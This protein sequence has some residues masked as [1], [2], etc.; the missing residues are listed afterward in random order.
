MITGDE[1]WI[2]YNNQTA[3]KEVE[4]GEAPERQAKIEI[5][6]KNCRKAALSDVIAQKRP[7]LINRKG[8]VFH[9][10]ARL[11]TSLVTRQKLLQHGWDMLPHPPYSPDLAPSDFHLLRSLNS[12][13]FAS[14]DLIKQHLDVSRR[15]GWEVL[16]T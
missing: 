4:V 1:K 15:E 10:N 16:R 2:V 6:Q 14:E 12:K 11:H 7:E 3:E 9:H 5:H 13:T 8:V